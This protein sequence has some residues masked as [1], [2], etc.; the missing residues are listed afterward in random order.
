MSHNN[1]KYKKCESQPEMTDR[2]I[3]TM[4]WSVTRYGESNR[5][6]I[7]KEVA[8]Y[9][10]DNLNKQLQAVADSSAEETKVVAETAENMADN[11]HEYNTVVGNVAQNTSDN[12]SKA[13]RTMADS[14]SRNSVN[15]QTSLENIQKK[16][17]DVA[18]SIR[19]MSTGKHGGNSGTYGGGGSSNVEDINVV[20]DT[21][22]FNARQ[23]SYNVTEIDFEEFQSELET[24]I[25]G[26]LD[27]ISNIDSQIDILKNLQDTFDDNGGIG[28]HGYADQIKQLEKEKEGLNNAL[29][30][31]SASSAKET[32]EFSEELNWV[33]KL[34]NKVS[35]ALDK[36]K[37]KVS[38]TYI[39]W[40]VRNHS[41]TKAMEKT[42]ETINVQQQAYEKY[43]QKAASVGL[44]QKY[45]DKIQNG[46][47]DIE[48]ITDES[49]NEQIRTYTEW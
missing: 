41:L 48:G 24:E 45:V 43:M 47:L 39:S 37:D 14:L 28:G 25:Q 2:H 44:S 3:T 27:A 9:K 32:K 18:D 38:N 22:N 13:A 5:L 29:K 49:L 35:S 12:I 10:L 42:N 20:I 19:D 7:S 1:P 31:T 36:L 8:I 46:T 33:E 17:W 40:S 26:Y 4:L 15:A 34:V 30:D 6:K 16:A 11:M 21:G 23:S